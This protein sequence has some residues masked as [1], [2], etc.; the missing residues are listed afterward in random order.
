MEWWE[1]YIVNF[2]AVYSVTMT[3]MY[4]RERRKASSR[5]SEVEAMDR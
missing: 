3:L 4:F 1:I 5:P 2:L